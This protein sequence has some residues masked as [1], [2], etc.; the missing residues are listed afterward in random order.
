MSDFIGYGRQ[1]ITDDDIRAVAETLRGD[2]LTQGPTVAAFEK[3]LADYCGVKHAVAC[4]NGTAAL[5]LACL[6]AEVG[7][8]DEVV[9]SAITFLASANCALYVGATPRFT[10]VDPGTVLMTPETLRPVLTD[11]TRAVIPVHMAGL[12]CDMKTIAGAV[13]R[14]RVT[15]IED[16]CHALGGEY[17]GG[18][19]GSCRF[20]DMSVLSFHPVKHITTGEGGAILTNRDDLYERLCLFRTHGM[21]KNPARLEK[22]DGPWYYEMHELGYNYRITDFQCALGLSQLKRLDAFVARRRE[23][24]DRYRAALRDA[25]NVAPLAVAP[26]DGHAYHLF[27]VRID[28][29]AVG[30]TRVEVV[31]ALRL[32]GVGVQVHYYPV[33]LQ[34]YYR[35]RFGFRPG[36]FPEAE[37]YYAQAL[38]LPMFPAMT[39]GDQRRVV[40]ALRS[41]LTS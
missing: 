11:R 12:S 9:T 19:V 13:D 32:R 4:A 27:V 18:K 2:W 36:Q 38:S 6:A 17:G 39:D 29:E 22:N 24:A 23:I 1:W 14:D 41:L 16:A 30:R 5:H 28:F 20:S 26:W 34:P 21:T 15:I 25:P 35:D 10:D 31:E 7:E 33:P 37:R 40:E 3:A 8:G